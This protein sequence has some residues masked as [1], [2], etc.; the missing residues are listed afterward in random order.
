M[1]ERKIGEMSIYGCIGNANRESSKI[2]STSVL[3]AYVRL[4]N[5]LVRQLDTPEYHLANS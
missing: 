3:V 4:I 1:R 5:K 2:A